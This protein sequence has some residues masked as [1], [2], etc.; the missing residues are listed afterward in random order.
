MQIA[1]I[2][3]EYNPFHLG[4]AYH[5]EQTRAAGA[6][7][8][9]SVMSG[10]FVQRGEPALFSK[11]ARAKAAILGGADLVIELPTPYV[12]ASAQTFAQAGV[13]LLDQLGANLL[14]FGSESGDL[15]LLEGLLDRAAAAEA[16]LEMNHFLKTGMSYPRARAAAIDLLFGK[17]W[18]S[19]IA[20]A[21]NLL[22]IEYIKAIRN[23]HSK[24]KPMTIRRMGAGHDDLHTADGFASA[25]CLRKLLTEG[26][27]ESALSL[28]PPVTR[29]I[30]KTE[31][32][33][34][35]A[36]IRKE[37]LDRLGL[38]KL[39]SMTAEDFARLS[40]VSEGLENRLVRAAG[41]AVSLADFCMRV[42]T[43]RYTLARIRRITCCALLDIHKELQLAPPSCIRVLAFNQRGTEI[44]SHAKQTAS[45]PIGTKFAELYRCCPAALSADIRATELAGL[46]MPSPSS[47]G[48]DFTQKLEVSNR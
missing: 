17:E 21:N 29:D 27:T 4:H 45:I 18:S 19:R 10:S 32:R 8:I 36:P 13:F 9:V 24:I 39:R 26:K 37:S 2:I 22:G 41:E 3:A 23:S 5:L 48:M 16:S 40:D 14:S 20:G 38:W 28:M 7:H 6:T 33:E 42:K 44:L 35:R 46:A 12:L 11:F 30:W 34:G 1:G 31:L 43:K 15:A 25:S 47:Q